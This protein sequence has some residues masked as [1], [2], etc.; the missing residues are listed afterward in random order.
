MTVSKLDD[1]SLSLI[2]LADVDLLSM[3]I[4]AESD[5]Q[6]QLRQYEKDTCALC[7]ELLKIHL[8]DYFCKAHVKCL[9]KQVKKRSRPVVS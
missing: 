9:L 7:G 8:A 5:Y 1:L 6:E 4:S 2:K 3:P